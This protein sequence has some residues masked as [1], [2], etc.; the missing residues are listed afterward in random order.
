MPETPIDKDGQLDSRKDDICSSRY[1][2]H[3]TDVNA[4]PVAV[5]VEPPPNGQFRLSVTLPLRLQ[6]EPVGL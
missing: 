2:L 3:R 1:H 6:P 4:V 5:S